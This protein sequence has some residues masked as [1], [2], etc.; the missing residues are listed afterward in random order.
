[1]KSRSVFL[2]IAA[3]AAAVVMTG[4]P[5]QTD[6][7]M[8]SYGIAFAEV[9]ARGFPPAQVGYTHVDALEVRV[10]NTGDSPT[11]DLR[12]T[13]MSD[14]FLPSRATLPS[15]AVGGYETFALIPVPDLYVGLHA[16]R[17]V[18]YGTFVESRY[19][20]ISFRVVQEL[21]DITPYFTCPNFLRLIR[22]GINI[23]APQPIF[24][25]DAE[26]I[27][28][29]AI[30][31]AYPDYFTSIA[32]IEHFTNLI[33][34]TANNG[35]L[36]YVDLSRNLR[37]RHLDLAHNQGY[38]ME[39]DVSFLVYLERLNLFANRLLYIRFGEQPYLAQLALSVNRFRELDLSSLPGLVALDLTRV[40]NLQS[41]CVRH[42][43]NLRYL[44][45]A[46]MGLT[47]TVD[48][49]RN[50]ELRELQI[51]ENSIDS[52]CLLHNHN[53]V[54]FTTWGNP[55]IA[56]VDFSNNREL[57]LISLIGTRITRLDLT[58]NSNLNVL[59]A[60]H[61]R[62][63]HTI[64]WP[65]ENNIHEIA[66]TGG[67]GYDLGS[68]TYF[69]PNAPN[70]RGATVRSQPLTRL[71]LSNTP[72]LEYVYFSGRMT[73][74]S[75][76]YMNFQGSGDITYLI[77]NFLGSD[78]DGVVYFDARDFYST[79]VRYLTLRGGFEEA[80]N[81]YR[82]GQ[83]RTLDVNYN[84]LEEL[85]VTENRDLRMLSVGDNRL[86]TLDVSG[87]S[88]LWFLWAEYNYL[89]RVY[90][91]GSGLGFPHPQ[92]GLA[93]VFLAFNSMQSIADVA[94][95][96]YLQD[97]RYGVNLDFRPQRHML[98]QASAPIIN[99]DMDWLTPYPYGEGWRL[100]NVRV[101]EFIEWPF[102]VLYDTYLHNRWIAYVPPEVAAHPSESLYLCASTGVMSGT[103]VP[104]DECD[105]HF[106]IVVYNPLG[107]DAIRVNIRVLPADDA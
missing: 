23:P 16:T 67:Q 50:P 37:L 26:D 64:V 1:M 13:V 52:I 18:V 49:S 85:D 102:E 72:Y 21:R 31:T 25:H 104:G 98:E 42:N 62:D 10:Y 73:N 43:P 106:Y 5:T 88:N 47:G 93:T 69:A 66:L 22:M 45:L 33:Y 9:D 89:T 78:G 91:E 57:R 58:N 103:P 83:L 6:N 36:C 41:V 84:Y 71:D 28:R 107:A 94:G 3:V 8:R 60:N 77:V 7:A 82:F 74:T 95:Y 75:L 30:G 39:I 34:L 29:I 46:A 86:T 80:R 2:I 38:M 56:E 100:P 87:L 32:G 97:L 40:Q 24:L 68:L 76:D 105:W 19:F 63:L 81:L 61:N 17:V 70:L 14:D 92:G 51:Q 96:D 15:I 27:Y 101:G 20:D 11:G 65:L 54:A 79:N 44:Y 90:V 12:I 53:L 35:R 4:C 48:L 59:I 55:N 99:T